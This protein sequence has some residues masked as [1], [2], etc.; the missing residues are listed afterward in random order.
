MIR[1]CTSCYFR[2]TD[3]EV[4]QCAI[5]TY[6][7]LIP[8]S[9][10]TDADISHLSAYQ[11][12]RTLAPTNP[13]TYSEK[14]IRKMAFDRNPLLTTFADKYRARSFVAEAVGEKYLSKIFDVAKSP[15]EINWQSLPSEYVCKV[16][17]G[18][19]GMV[20]VWRGSTSE[21]ALPD[22]VSGVD[23]SRH[24]IHPDNADPVR[25]KNLARHWLSQNFTWR[26]NAAPEWAYQNIEP[27]VYAEELIGLGTGLSPIDYKFF[28]FN[29][30]TRL[31]QVRTHEPD[32]SF[33]LLHF[34]RNWNH[35]DIT[36]NDGSEVANTKIV[37]D[38]PEN[39]EELLFV[40]EKLGESVDAV[41]VDLYSQEG[42][43]TFGELTN[44]TCAGISFWTPYEFNIELGDW[45]KQ[46]Y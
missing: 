4:A 9:Q 22:T 41:R 1:F 28:V 26:P 30:I 33:S 16:N 18:S 45:W 40:A 10:L 2:E 29:G 23:W 20:A 19:G 11:S 25:I 7:A 5:C 13:K 37:R 39:L 3:D 43:I 12:L 17:H 38:R 27:L 44:Y 14:I 46:N 32:M 15:D 36:L 34:D 24:W 6:S 21:S 42:R 35:I 8:A 31:I